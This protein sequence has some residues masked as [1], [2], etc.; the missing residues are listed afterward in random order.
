MAWVVRRR[1]AELRSCD[2]DEVSLGF[3]QSEGRIEGGG[4]DW[5]SGEE[6]GIVEED[7]GPYCC[8]ELGREWLACC[9]PRMVGGNE[10]SK[11]QLER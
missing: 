1:A 8:C 7:G 9:M 2:G 6:G 4:T 11:C 3:R 5:V 10:R